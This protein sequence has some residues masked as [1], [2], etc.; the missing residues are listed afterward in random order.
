MATSQDTLKAASRVRLG[1]W[2]S[3]VPGLWPSGDEVFCPRLG[4]ARRE[5]QWWLYCTRHHEFT[6]SIVCVLAGGPCLSGYPGDR[7]ESQKA[8]RIPTRGPVHQEH[9]PKGIR[10]DTNWAGA[11]PSKAGGGS[12]QRDHKIKLFI[13]GISMFK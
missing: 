9:T 10:A 12:L 8:Q 7:S 4:K 11:G 5:Q 13:Y 3:F 1:V 6:N 2:K